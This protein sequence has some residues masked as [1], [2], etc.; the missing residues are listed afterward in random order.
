MGARGR[1]KRGC[2]TA[3][4]SRRLLQVTARKI[5]P[6]SRGP[7]VILLGNVPEERKERA[8]PV[9][10]KRLLAAA[11]LSRISYDK[12]NKLLRDVVGT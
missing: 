1:G 3:T 9:D 6:I 7:V 5:L 10:A 12:R 4:I 8:P 2:C 11:Q